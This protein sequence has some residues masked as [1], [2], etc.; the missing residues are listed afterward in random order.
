MD[1]SNA[2]TADFVVIGGG[3]AGLMAAAHLAR[4]GRSV[5]L[6]ERATEPGG[7]ARTQEF[8]GF[9]FNQGAHALSSGG[10][11]RLLNE[12]GVTIRGARPPVSGGFALRGGRLH[13]LPAGP[14]SL[15]TTRL[16]S[17]GQKAALA[18]LM[19]SV[20]RLD[21]AFWD[22]VPA[23]RFLDKQ[24]LAG[25]GRELFEALLRL[26]T[27]CNGPELLDA[28]AALR[29]LK[30]EQDDGVL[31]LDR[32]WGSIVQGLAA[33]AAQL[34][35][36]I[37]PGCTARAVGPA[38]TGFRV[39][40][41][42][43]RQLACTGVVLAVSPA[44]CCSLLPPGVAARLRDFTARAVP[45][46]AACLDLALR[47]LPRPSRLFALGIDRPLYFSVHSSVAQLS[48]AG[49]ALVHAIKYLA[50]G[51]APDGEA[52]REVEAL[53]DR[54]QPGWR[55]LIVER[56]WLP[57]MTVSH[58]LV[59]ASEGGLAGRPPALIED[60]PGLAVAGDWVGPQGLLADASCASGRA[61][62]EALLPMLAG[63]REAAA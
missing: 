23:A 28:G 35:A 53:M 8:G 51:A 32:G 6:I 58:A 18:R 42:D 21:P 36:R 30:L 59:R 19:S 60:L 7:R 22:G 10:A 34:G 52:A 37:L 16:L 15:L 38:G 41:A 25:P 33:R 54:V 61:A 27:Y 5:D 11:A 47:S 62:A 46:Q 40:L 1:A 43:G 44:A 20:P 9:F 17:W 57:R 24:R 29:Q 50:P 14:F 31:Y 56:R 45:V 3:L 48:P 49:G 63:S 26:T 4:A 12:I 39:S 2:R 55:D 13:R